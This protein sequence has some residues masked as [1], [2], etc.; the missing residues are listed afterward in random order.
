MNSRDGVEQASN[1]LNQGAGGK[2][3]VRLLPDHGHYFLGHA[4][5][6][7]AEEIAIGGADNDIGSRAAVPQRHIVRDAVT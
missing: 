1:G 4:D 3:D 5:A 7:Q 2:R 6:T